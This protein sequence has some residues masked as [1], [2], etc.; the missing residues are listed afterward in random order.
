MLQQPALFAYIF[1][2]GQFCRV[3]QIFFIGVVWAL[4]LDWGRE[5]LE[6]RV[7]ETPRTCYSS[8]TD[9][10]FTEAETHRN[11]FDPILPSTA[12]NLCYFDFKY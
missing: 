1:S 4:I 2:F 12:T 9:V 8:Y 11:R 10:A 7:Y 3:R 5:T 6:T